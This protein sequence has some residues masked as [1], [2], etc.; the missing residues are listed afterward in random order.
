MSG[1]D[2]EW[3]QQKSALKKQKQ[4]E[5]KVAFQMKDLPVVPPP[6]DVVVVPGIWR[7][8]VTLGGLWLFKGI[9]KGNI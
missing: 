1:T 3:K 8:V 9:F 7:D 6:D 5:K 4:A 2:T